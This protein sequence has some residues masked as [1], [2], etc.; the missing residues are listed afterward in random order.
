MNPDRIEYSELAEQTLLGLGLRRVNIENFVRTEL[1]GIG[2]EQALTASFFG[3]HRAIYISEIAIDRGDRLRI[4]WERG[5]S[6]IQVWH[7]DLYEDD[8]S[9]YYV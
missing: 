6:S 4:L 7:L 5:I 9:G 3:T 1:L 2:V 8:F